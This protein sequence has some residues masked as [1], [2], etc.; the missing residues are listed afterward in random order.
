MF[1]K[2]VYA[3]IC[4]KT[5]GLKTS[6]KSKIRIRITDYL[7]IATSNFR[8]SVHC[9]FQFSLLCVESRLTV[10]NIDQLCTEP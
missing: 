5:L 9:N 8:L 1:L 2:V 4:E 3:Y 6:K 10:I 7:C